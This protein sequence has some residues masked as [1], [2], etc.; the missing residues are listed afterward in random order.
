M[1][2]R[3]KDLRKLMMS[4][5]TIMPKELPTDQKAMTYAQETI[6]RLQGELVDKDRCNARSEEYADREIKRLRGALERIIKVVKN[7]GTDFGRCLNVLRIAR[8]TLEVE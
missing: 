7:D 5:P 8:E 6:E 4:L 1:R 3:D 2:K